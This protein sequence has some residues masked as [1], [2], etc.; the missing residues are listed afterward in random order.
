MSYAVPKK[1]S[2]TEMTAAADDEIFVKLIMVDGKGDRVEV[3]K[4]KWDTCTGNN[5]M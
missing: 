5:L 1:G 3:Q 2:F 4:F